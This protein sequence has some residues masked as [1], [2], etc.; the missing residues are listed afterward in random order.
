MKSRTVVA[1]LVALG[2]VFAAAAQRTSPAAVLAAE[3][4]QLLPEVARAMGVD[5]QQAAINI[6]RSER[7]MPLVEAVKND[8]KHF[9][10]IKFNNEDG[11]FTVFGI[12]GPADARNRVASRIPSDLVVE[13]VQVPYSKDE[14]QSSL[15]SGLGNFA[16]AV[17]RDAVVGAGVE[18]SSATIPLR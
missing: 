13:F 11:S 14:L 18:W 15:E 17:G 2:L 12:D 1:A 6:D 16:Q 3:V 5:E 4:Q 10:E 7:G 9:L 8:A